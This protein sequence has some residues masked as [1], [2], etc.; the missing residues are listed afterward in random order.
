[1]ILLFRNDHNNKG[2]VPENRLKLGC[3]LSNSP[4]LPQW[5]QSSYGFY[6]ILAEYQVLQNEIQSSQHII[7]RII[8]RKEMLS[9][10]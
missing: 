8:I 6:V 5:N 9:I 4:P 3:A 7:Y 10:G 2:Q 1:M